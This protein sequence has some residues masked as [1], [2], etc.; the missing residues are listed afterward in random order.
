VI[1]F[2]FEYRMTLPGGI[3]TSLFGFQMMMIMGV[4]SLLL[5]LVALEFSPDFAA[6][7]A[8]SENVRITY[9]LFIGALVA[10]AMVLYGG[11]ASSPAVDFAASTGH[12]LQIAGSQ[13]PAGFRDVLRLHH[14][15]NADIAQ[16]RHV[17]S[18]HGSPFVIF[19]VVAGLI[20]R[21]T[22]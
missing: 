19:R 3:D 20:I 6:R 11:S 8:R 14:E 12:G 16:D 5:A 13:L 18:F 15:V 21:R 10:L 22:V 2:A 4:L 7:A 17:D 1:F 9:F